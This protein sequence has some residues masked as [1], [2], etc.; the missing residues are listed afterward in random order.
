MTNEEKAKAYDH[1]KAI[2][3][4]SFERRQARIS[5]ILEKAVKAGIV[6]TDAEVDAE[7]KRRSAKK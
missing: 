1:I 2:N 5:L 7:I 6:V 3:Q 4:R